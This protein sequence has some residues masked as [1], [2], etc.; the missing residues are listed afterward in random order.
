[1]KPRVGHHSP[2]ALILVK[3]FVFLQNGLMNGPGIVAFRNFMGSW[4][5]KNYLCFEMALRNAQIKQTREHQ[6]RLK[7][8]R[9]KYPLSN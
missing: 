1:M 7:L 9:Q 2:T 6:K 8:M 3:S 4:N 5:V